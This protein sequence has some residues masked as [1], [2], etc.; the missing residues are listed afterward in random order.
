MQV[1]AVVVLGAHALPDGTLTAPLQDRVDK[2]I[3]LYNEGITKTLIMS[4]GIDADGTDEALAMKEYAVALGVP[5]SAIIVDSFGNTTDATSEN[6]VKIAEQYDFEQ[7]GAVSS[8]YHMARIK[9]LFLAKCH[10]I[11][12]FPATPVYES[13]NLP[14]NTLR[15]IP[16]WWYYYFGA[17]FG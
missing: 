11:Y 4:G 15:E 7:L 16:G 14:F 13:S 9:M 12:T 8:Y 10:N 1:D 6:V 17:V 3:A 2:A 5:E